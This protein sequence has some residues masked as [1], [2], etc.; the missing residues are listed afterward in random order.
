ML[1]L[2]TS[3]TDKECTASQTDGQTD[4]TDSVTV[5]TI[6]KKFLLSNAV[7]NEPKNKLGLLLNRLLLSAI[8]VKKLTSLKLSVR[9]T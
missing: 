1:Q 8:N 5:Y 7:D 3:Y 6:G 4:D 2:S 9:T